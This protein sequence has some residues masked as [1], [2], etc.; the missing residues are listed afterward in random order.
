MMVL[1]QG[2]TF[3]GWSATGADYWMMGRGLLDDGLA[4]GAD[5]WMMVLLQVRTIACNDRE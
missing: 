2:R 4:S 5:Y 1:L 3:G